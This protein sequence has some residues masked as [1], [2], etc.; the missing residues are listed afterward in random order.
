[1]PDVP[2]HH[3]LSLRACLDDRKVMRRLEER[4]K[5]LLSIF[6]N[7]SDVI[8]KWNEPAVW[9]DGGRL[10]QYMLCTDD[11]EVRLRNQ[12][13]HEFLRN[14][15]EFLC[16]HGALLPRKSHRGKLL[17]DSLYSALVKVIMDEQFLLL[18]DT[19]SIVNASGSRNTAL[20]IYPSSQVVCDLGCVS[21]YQNRVKNNL[22]ILRKIVSLYNHLDPKT[23]HRALELDEAYR[24]ECG[25]HENYA[26]IISKK[27]INIIRKY[28]ERLM[29]FAAESETGEAP[30]EREFL[31]YESSSIADGIASFSLLDKNSC[32][33]I[34][35]P[36]S[37]DDNFE[38]NREITCKLQYVFQ[39]R[40]S[41]VH[42]ILT[43]SSIFF[44]KA[45]M[46]IA[47][48]R[49]RNTF[50]TSHIRYGSG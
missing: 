13:A 33:K 43:H 47:M 4:R 46:A 39:L 41:S 10:R 16:D 9:I 49:A 20:R 45:R 34:G 2:S 23:D 37:R 28:V 12:G 7:F 11:L 32:I 6:K 24:G 31:D 22:S 18:G 44:Y 8:V 27:D 42:S 25:R 35:L 14:E 19:A 36:N 3:L 21:D 1:M 50:G 17:S 30:L 29:K 5:S 26:Y 15:V 40:P 38:I 48:Y